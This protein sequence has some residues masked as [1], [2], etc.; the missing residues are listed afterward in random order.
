[1]N[2]HLAHNAFCSLQEQCLV[3]SSVFTEMKSSSLPNVIRRCLVLDK[4]STLTGMSVS[5]SLLPRKPLTNLSVSMGLLF[6]THHITKSHNV[7]SFV[8][9]F[10]HCSWPFILFCVLSWTGT[11]LLSNGWISSRWE[12]VLC[13]L[14]PVFSWWTT[15]LAYVRGGITSLHML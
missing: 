1:M 6:L 11:L 12:A 10:P 13:L 8:S 9:K 15:G 14:D 3:C 7:W 2:A 5:V 4:D